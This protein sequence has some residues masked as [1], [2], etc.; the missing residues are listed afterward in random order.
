MRVMDNSP[1]D[2]PAVGR[3]VKETYAVGQL[4]DCCLYVLPSNASS[5]VE[6]AKEVFDGWI[7]TKDD[8]YDDGDGAS[9]TEDFP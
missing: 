3:L 4:A 8:T 5:M 1:I 2:V 9:N 7:K 6:K